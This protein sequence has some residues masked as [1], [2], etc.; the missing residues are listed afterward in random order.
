MS[1]R[2]VLLLKASGILLIFFFYSSG[3][4]ATDSIS[5][6]WKNN[7][8][9]DLL[10]QGK[11]QESFEE[12]SKLLTEKPFHQ[13]YQYNTGAAFFSIEEVE[14]A[15]KMY[16]E[17]LAQPNLDPR[18]EFAAYFNMGV[19]YSLKEGG[20]VDRALEFYQKGLALRPESKE[21]KTNIELLLKQNPGGGKGKDKNKKKDNENGEGEQEKEPQKFTNEQQNEGQGKN[22]NQQD[23]RRI[24]EELKKQEQKIR[25]K[26]DRK[27]KKEGS[28]GKNW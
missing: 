21:I 3:V 28:R 18:I 10:V 27:G 15:K 11:K 8:G 13:L 7:R 23:V 20:D 6:I 22:L 2:G 1:G 19:L 9:V 12:F 17:L 5:D 26:H 4:F 24:M 16:G 25:A 14:K